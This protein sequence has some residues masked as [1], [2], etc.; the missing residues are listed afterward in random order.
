MGKNGERKIS[1]GCQQRQRAC[2]LPCVRQ[3]VEY[4]TADC[5]TKERTTVKLDYFNPLKDFMQACG[6][7]HL[8]A[9]CMVAAGGN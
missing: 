8:K 1:T 5:S 9:R 4:L 6:D 3:Y 2:A 7:L